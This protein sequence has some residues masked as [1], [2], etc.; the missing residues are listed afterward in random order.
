MIVSALLDKKF[1]GDDALL[2]L[3]SLRLRQDGL[4]AEFNVETPAE[5]AH[6]YGFK[7][8]EDAPVFAHLSRELNLL[9]KADRECI[10]EFAAGFGDRI[11]GF[12]VHD[13]RESVQRFEAYVEALRVL[14]HRF[15]KERLTSRLFIEYASGLVPADYIL[16]F[17]AVMENKH[18]SACID[19]GH[20]GLWQANDFFSSRRPGRKLFRLRPDSPDLPAFIEDIQAAVGSSLDTLLSLMEALAGIGKPVHFHLHDGHPLSASSPYGLSDHLSFLDRIPVPLVYDGKE[21]LRLMYGPSGLSKIVSEAFR[22]FGRD[23]VSFT[24]EIHPTGG[25]LPLGDAAHLF[26]HWED[27]TNAERMNHWL[28]VLCDNHVLLTEFGPECK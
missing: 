26:R 22:L 1:E 17:Q 6:L 15:E 13:Q 5:L 20:V 21:S 8:F 25:R 3:A 19:T 16:L 24:L 18:I 27:K 9:R 12:I 2:R 7:P 28:S 10:L 4:G 11:R 14:A 23:D